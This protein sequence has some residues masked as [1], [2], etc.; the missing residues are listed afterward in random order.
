MRHMLKTFFDDHLKFFLIFLPVLA[1]V[2][3]CAKK[4]SSPDY[5]PEI[6]GHALYQ[7]SLDLRSNLKVLSIALR[8]GCEDFAA[9]AYF[10][11]GRGAVVM[12]LYV[13]NGEGGE[14]DVQGEYPTH[15]AAVRRAEA[16]RA[17][18]YLDGDARFLNFPD[19][20]AARD[21]TPIRQ[22]W[23]GDSLQFKLS[24]VISQFQPDLVLL[25]RDWSAE[26]PSLIWEILRA[27]LLTAVKSV[28]GGA[29]VHLANGAN[30]S[31]AWTVSRVVIDIGRSERLA[32]PTSVQHPRWKKSYGQIGEEAAQM[33][34]SLVVQ[35]KLWRHGKTTPDDSPPAPTPPLKNIDDGVPIPVSQRL[36]GIEIQIE[37]L[38][39]KTL[40][41]KTG[42]VLPRVAALIDS[43]DLTFA[44]RQTT[45]TARERKSLLQWKNALE[46]L[47]CTLLGVEVDYAV[48]ETM[49]SNHQLT[50]IF[51]NQVKGL[52]ADGKTDIFFAGLDENWAVNEDAKHRLPLELK[53]EYRLLTPEKLAYSFPPGRE[54]FQTTPFAKPVFLFILHQAKS[55]ERSFVHR[56][57]I[58]FDFA[59][60]FVAEVL[61]PIVRMTPGE[62]LV[63]RLTNISRDG[64][65]DTVEVSDLLAYAFPH[66]FR[67]SQKGASKLDTLSL[68]WLGNPAEGTYLFPVRIDTF[69]IAR[70]AARKFSAEVDP[71]KRV[72]LITGIINSPTAE[73]LRR[74]RLNFFTLE[75]NKTSIQQI[76][77]LDVLIIDRR[78][79]SLKP[80]IASLRP[81]FDRFVERGGHLIVLGQDAAV[82]NDQP[83][84]NGISLT[85]INTLDNNTPLQLDAG[86]ALLNRPNYLTPEDWED[87]L[88][89]RGYNTVAGEVLA[90]TAIPAR[91]LPE[92][93]P[94]IVSAGAGK[95]KR[96]YVDLALPPQLMN[97]HAGAFRLLANLI[98][99]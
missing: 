27:D 26:T 78:A 43:V 64:V 67:L 19:I 46:N 20:V 76:E 5:F 91:A 75:P 83:L 22:L 59:P 81:E 39:E 34:A 70:F 38:T 92:G 63:I 77:A 94:L 17:M 40:N 86:H 65:A 99:Y 60:K 69:R 61:T 97:I 25:A 31:P 53:Q 30:A 90:S 50:S 58:N 96:T 52:T 15:L 36:R 28:A 66:P 2:C 55:S 37:A 73:A 8:P 23:P 1:L 21:S 68:A 84:W 54:A 51:V 7:R 41:G 29:A 88:F 49:L 95:G 80:E 4:T 9:L 3:S 6:G 12:S 82:W 14:S 72:G 33:Y 45:L 56:R 24:E 47:R 57:I 79:L 62:R 89:L 71:S 93:N 74:L 32:I 11:L 10:R 13:T 18:T 44:F 48:T 85:S 98:S 87:W 35:R 16:A 42:E